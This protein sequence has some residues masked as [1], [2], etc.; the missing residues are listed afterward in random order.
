MEK[1]SR[2]YN[3]ESMVRLVL[4]THVQVYNTRQQVSQEYK[5]HTVWRGKHH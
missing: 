2:Q 3:V 5:M 4:I 1:T